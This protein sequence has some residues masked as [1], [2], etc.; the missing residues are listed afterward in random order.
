VEWRV[1]DPVKFLY[2]SRDPA[3]LLHN[4]IQAEARSVVASFNVDE[5]LTSARPEIQQTIWEGAINKINEYDLGIMISRVT[6]QDVEPPTAEVISAFM[7]VVNARE[8]RETEINRAYTY[9][10]EII[11][12]AEAEADRITK[13]AEG[14][15][16]A[17]I[18]EAR[19]QFARFNEMFT[20]YALNPEI[21]RTR[22]YLETMEQVLPGVTVYV[23]DS[24]SSDILKILNL[25]E[26]SANEGRA[27]EG[28]ANESN[29]TERITGEGGDRE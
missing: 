23:A 19:G 17:R 1:S 2:N 24:N 7:D 15:K 11:P 5:V 18:N 6:I 3:S 14:V 8:H 4:I 13:E 28:R 9:R 21:T 16:E 27:N 22:L 29:N 10:N 26:G 20:E 12:A 25:N